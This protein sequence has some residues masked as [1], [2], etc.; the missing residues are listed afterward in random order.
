[1]LVP[2]QQTFNFF[3]F[4]NFKTNPGIVTTLDNK[5]HGLE[6]DDVVTFKEVKGMSQING[7][8]FKVKGEQTLSVKNL[9]SFLPLKQEF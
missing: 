4:Y 3:F 6:T 1:M 2:S 9:L 7:K 8:E 5:M